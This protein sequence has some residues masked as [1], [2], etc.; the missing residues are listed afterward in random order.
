[1]T[2]IETRDGAVTGVRTVAGGLAAPAVLL[3]AGGMGYAA[4]GGTDAGYRLATAAGH[5]VVAPVPAN[6]PL[7]TADSWPGAL[8]GVTLPRAGLRLI[9]KGAR[10]TGWQGALLF[11]HRGISG[12]AALDASGDIARELAAGGGVAV[13]LDFA[14][15]APPAME[16]TSRWRAEHPGR[17]AAA[18]LRPFVPASLA[19]ALCAVADVPPD[20]A[21][22]RM[23][24]AQVE[25]LATVLRACPLTIAATEGFEKAMVTRGG[26]SLKEIAPATLESRR[27]RGLHF[28]GEVV[29]LDGPCGGYNLQW[30][31]SSGWLAGRVAAGKAER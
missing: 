20:L 31:F 29:D 22:G 9:G 3:A 25:R 6:V 17:T 24:R 2:A 12:P 14:P 18:A 19:A 5:S 13:A 7:V 30:A 23:A 10:R 1:V 4:L 15:D 26:V 28:A 27:V 8:A 11:T 21:G 16:W